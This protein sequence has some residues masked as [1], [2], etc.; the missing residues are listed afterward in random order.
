[1][2]SHAYPPT[3]LIGDYGR[4]GLGLAFV[5]PPL[6]VIS[7]IQVVGAAC[8]GL[9]ALF[10]AFAA[11]TLLRQLASIEM[12]E[13]GIGASGLWPLWLEWAALDDLSLRYYATRRDREGG[14]MQLVLRARGGRLR[15]DSRIAGFNVI[16]ARAVRAAEARRLPLS[17]ITVANLAALG[18]AIE[19]TDDAIEARR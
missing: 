1:M 5:V 2:T 15:L 7:P 13:R 17:P 12:D 3:A 4:A 6:F 11:R 8:V 10:T 9:A 14:W 18:L 19:G 16:A